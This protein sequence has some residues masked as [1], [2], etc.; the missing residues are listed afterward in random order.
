MCGV[1]TGAG[2]TAQAIV[3]GT[4]CPSSGSSVVLV[5]L[6]D[7]DRQPV[8]A[9]SGTVIGRRA[10]LTAAHCLVGDTALVRVY[11]G[12]GDQI[13]AASFTAFP[14]YREHDSSTLDVGVV[15]TAQDI[16]RTVIPLLVSRDARVGEQAVIAG[17]GMDQ[18]GT[19]TTLRAAATAIAA[20]TAG[21]LE[22]RIDTTGS[23]VCSGDSGGPLFLSES[24][25]W[26][27]A[28]VT[29][30]GSTGGS[31]VMGSNYFS[32]LRHP[33]VSAFVLGLVPDAIR[34]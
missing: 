25:A 15:I 4:A 18:F 6:Q 14:G 27:V 23:G 12:S 24:G 30:A 32:N 22:T 9:C 28:G 5:N 1:L 3:S 20:V 21:F 19:G 34:R 7:K 31:C 13:P 11:P 17:W 26:A 8:G 33:D 29:S 2:G 16:D 10:V